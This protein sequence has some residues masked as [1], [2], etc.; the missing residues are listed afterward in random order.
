[1]GFS[2]LNSLG[3]LKQTADTILGQF[4]PRGDDGQDGEDFFVS[5]PSTQFN[6][7]SG[8]W[9]P[10]IN[11]G[12]GATGITY[13]TQTGRYI[14]F[15]PFVYVEGRII[16]TS[17]GSSTGAA[18]IEGLPFIVTNESNQFGGIYLTNFG[19]FNTAFAAISAYLL[20]GGTNANLFNPAGA[21]NIVDTDFKNNTDLAFVGWFRTTAGTFSPPPSSLSTSE[22]IVTTTGNIDDLD[23]S[24][25][26]LIRMN[27]ASLS[28]I[29]G[30]KAGTAGQQVTIVSVGAGQVN[31]AHQDT[32]DGTPAS[33]LINFVT[34]G[35]TPLAAGTGTAIYQYDGTTARWRLIK[36]DQGAWITPSFSAGDY[37]ANGSMTWTVGSGDVI[38]NSY[39]VV[40]KSLL[41]GIR[42]TTT[43]VGGTPNTA[44]RLTLPNGY[45]TGA[46]V[47][48]AAYALNDNGAGFVAGMISVASGVTYIEFYHAG[49]AGNW[50]AATDNTQIAAQLFIILT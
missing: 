9:T 4:G 24:N 15:G 37:T 32:G 33:R 23:F 28:T 19:S 36:H 50:A 42:L 46:N 30:L 2:V 18:T 20:P 12:G 17:K 14:K 43:T 6:P 31:L 1:M 27:N 7:T 38:T 35:V 41:W 16:L 22:Y 3:Q 29:R 13:S 47:D 44:L 10:A 5:I 34:S 49:F 25:A 8:S 48:G 21:A 40:G 26:N 39:L 45:T 11:F